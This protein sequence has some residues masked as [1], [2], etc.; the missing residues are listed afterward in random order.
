M[1]RDRSSRNAPVIEKPVPEKPT[2]VSFLEWFIEKSE[3]SE[4]LRPH[5]MDAVKAYFAGQGLKNEEPAKSFDEA[6]KRY[7]I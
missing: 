4:E 1:G 3:R 2:T 7:G 6:L 5:H